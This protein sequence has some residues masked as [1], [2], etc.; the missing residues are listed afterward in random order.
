[1]EWAA[2]APQFTG[3]LQKQQGE[4][5]AKSPYII[6]RHT[7]ESWS[8][9]VPELD[10]LPQFFESQSALLRQC[11]GTD[12]GRWSRLFEVIIWRMTMIGQR[13]SR[14]WLH[15]DNT[16]LASWQAILRGAKRFFICAP[17]QTPHLSEIRLA[18]HGETALSNTGNSRISTAVLPC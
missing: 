16:V 14:F 9:I 13:G 2:A 15:Y 8:A 6:W 10:P 7:L 18:K 5:A 12:A 4:A 1:M 17:D 3:A 11:I